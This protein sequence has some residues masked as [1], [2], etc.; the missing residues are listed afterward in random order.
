MARRTPIPSDPAAVPIRAVAEAALGVARISLIRAR[1][2]TCVCS[3][4]SSSSWAESV[5]AA[6]LA[7]RAEL[8]KRTL[9][10]PTPSEFRETLY[11][12]AKDVD[13]HAGGHYAPAA[14]TR[15]ASSN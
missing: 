4:S 10:A 8:F 6:G 5:A 13:Q 14:S 12:R 2:A 11:H 9:D 15:S 3:R 7:R 1:T